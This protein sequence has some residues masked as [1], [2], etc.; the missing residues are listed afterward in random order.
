MKIEFTDSN[1]LTVR[2]PVVEERID[3]YQWRFQLTPVEAA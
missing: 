2:L 1:Q 3:K